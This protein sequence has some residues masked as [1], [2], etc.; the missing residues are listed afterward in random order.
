M[1]Q[2]IKRTVGFAIAGD[3][4][5]TAGASFA[6]R[7]GGDENVGVGSPDP[8]FLTPHGGGGGGAGSLNSTDS[9]IGSADN[10]RG[11]RPRARERV[12]RP[13]SRTNPVPCPPPDPIPSPPAPPTRRRPYD[14][15]RRLRSLPATRA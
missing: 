14:R 3:E 10:T 12:T 11:V 5:E 8:V 6:F 7:A 15:S 2:P 9:A 1:A 13:E 4:D